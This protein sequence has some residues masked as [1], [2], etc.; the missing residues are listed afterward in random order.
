MT[1][2]GFPDT[3]DKCQA[4]YERWLKKV[5]YRYEASGRKIIVSTSSYICLTETVPSSSCR[6]NS[7]SHWPSMNCQT[8]QWNGTSAA[9]RRNTTAWP[10][11]AGRTTSWRL[12]SATWLRGRQ[13]WWRI[14]SLPLHRKAAL[15]QKRDR[16]TNPTGEHKPNKKN[17][18]WVK[19][20]E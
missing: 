20:L 14:T 16:D 18:E 4:F 17:T 8:S 15:G 9:S 19:N 1:P 7:T 5:A 10:R 2:D 12:A 3:K 13:N 6:I 11:I